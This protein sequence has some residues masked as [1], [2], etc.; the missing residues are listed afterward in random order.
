M[1][2]PDETAHPL[3][4]IEIAPLGYAP[5]V[6]GIHAEA[7]PLVRV[8]CPFAVEGEGRDHGDLVPRELRDEGV[9]LQDGLIR[10]ASRAVELYDDRRPVVYADLIHAVFVAVERQEPAI[11]TE[12]DAFERVEHAVGCEAGVGRR[13]HAGHCT[14]G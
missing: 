8:E 11:A 13:G 5:T 14:L 6:F 1:D 2:A 3:Q 9:F 7:E 4:D 12:A 10:P